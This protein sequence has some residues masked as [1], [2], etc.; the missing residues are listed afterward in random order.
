MKKLLLSVL[1][2][3]AIWTLATAQC[4]TTNATGCQC[5][6]PSQTDCDLLPDIQIGHPPFYQ[7][8]QTYGYIE[9]AQT[10]NGVDNGRLKISVSTP[11]TGHGAL[12][13]RTTNIF[14]C[15]TDTFIGSAPSICPDGVSY[16]RILINQRIYHKN[17]NTMT[18][19][20]RPAGTM[21][22]H[23]TH[24]HL[25]VDNWGT[26]TLRTEDP[27]EPNPLNWP[28]I[29]AGTKLAF[30]VMDYGN[31]G[32]ASYQDHCLD[33]AGNSMNG[34]SFF[35]NYGLGGG[36]YNCSQS[37][38][39]ISSGY[40]DIYWTSLDGMWI[41][42]PP[43]TCNGN[44]WIVTE[45]DPNGFFLEEYENNNVYA[46]PVTLTRQSTGPNASTIAV[47]NSKTTICPGESVILS[48]L[49]GPAG[50]TYQWSTGE[51]TPTIS[52]NQPGTYTVNVTSS[53]GTGT[54]LPVTISMAPAVTD[55]TVDGD[56]LQTPGTAVLSATGTGTLNWYDAPSGGTLLASGSSYTTPMIY[57]S[58][59]YYVEDEV[60]IPG[61][62]MQ[63][64]PATNTTAGAGSSST[65][66]NALVFDCYNPF[67]LH[68]V[69]VY[70]QTAGSR[71]IELRD[72]SG[73]VL[74]ST[75]VQVVAGQ[76]TVVLD[77]NITPGTGYRLAKPS[78]SQELY[79]NN[80]STGAGYPYTIQ[81]FCSITG[82]TATSN[83]GN[84]YYFFYNWDIRLPDNTCTSSRVPVEAYVASPSVISEAAQLNSLKVFPN[85]ATAQ[86]NVSFDLKTV[87]NAT[88][89]MIDAVG[90]QVSTRN[91][92]SS[93]GKFETSFDVSNIAKGIYSIHI[94]SDNK[95]Y[96][97][98]LV[99]R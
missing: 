7:P 88:V 79:R 43:G 87:N 58:T 72:A 93:N 39:G 15:G 75:V 18:Y 30:C 63:I 73:N 49:S 32:G 99:V 22:Y 41:Q 29:G 40:L 23:P 89:E 55:P 61:Q 45:V 67:T 70:A 17:G 9:Y 36:S 86:V 27:N 69:D 46:S 57:T 71:T 2:L 4:T 64:G 28:I 91:L 6:D 47:D 50:T 54:S 12:E 35:P 80:V 92:S 25:H 76:N 20:D 78:S 48:A 97:S 38:Q 81:N 37:V 85:P 33:T 34:A 56:S 95:N 65:S 21:T 13:L 26:Y 74:Q 68:A 82:S 16:P 10:G 60:T 84:Y 62:Q 96:Y 77:F 51:T 42:I 24:G 94:L 44:Y 14:V 31:C 52:V 19:Y 11:N 53:C 1:F 3:L 98:K 83:P 8:G 59:M 66:T 90:H 5:K